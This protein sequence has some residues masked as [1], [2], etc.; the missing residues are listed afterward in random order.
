MRP[1]EAIEAITDSLHGNHLVVSATGMTSRELFTVKD[2]DRN[3][4]MIGPM[5]LAAPVGLGLALSLP[6][7]QVVVIDRDGS[8]MMGRGSLSTIGKLAPANLLHVVLSQDDWDAASG[9]HGLAGGLDNAAAGA[10]YRMVSRVASEDQLRSVVVEAC[11]H[12]P[13]FV[14]VMIEQDRS[15][16]QPRAARAPGEAGA[17]F[18]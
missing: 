17:R 10:G 18:R 6:E 5:G 11:G 15:G 7:K 2:S 13:A 9:Q 1:H 8:V 12:G 14:L 4:Y 16:E 3:F